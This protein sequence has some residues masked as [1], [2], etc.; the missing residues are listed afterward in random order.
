MKNILVVQASP[1]RAESSCR[2]VVTALVERLTAAYPNAVVTSRELT[3]NPIPHFSD[4]AVSAAS[5]P[6]SVRTPE[7]RKAL[8]LSEHLCAELI[9]ADVLVV[10]TPMWNFS[11]PS[12]LKAWV[13]HLVRADLTFR[14]EKGGPVGIL[15]ASKRL[16]LVESSGGDYASPEA[17]PMNHVAPYLR[18]VFGFLGILDIQTITIAGTAYRRADAV[19]EGLDRVLQLQL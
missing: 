4:S 15:P 8:E 9:A 5:T 7:Q 10:G 2:K 12:V 13:D 16:Y 17:S 11:V 1:S 14:Y 6:A 19:Q 3:L 18:Q